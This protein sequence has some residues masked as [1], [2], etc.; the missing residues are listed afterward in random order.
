MTEDSPLGIAEPDFNQWKHHPVT[1]AFRQYLIDYT[2]SLE[3]AHVGRWR[4]GDV[5]EKAE[6]W[7]SGQIEGIEEIATL[8]FEHI[9]RFY[10]QNQEED[11][12][13]SEPA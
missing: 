1:K 3:V 7:A 8:E 9:A 12:G 10:E 5:D 2:K 11:N 6:S 4:A 13:S